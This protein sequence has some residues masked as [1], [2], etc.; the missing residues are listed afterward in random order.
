MAEAIT[1]GI[2]TIEYKLGDSQKINFPQK[3]SKFDDSQRSVEK[4]RGHLPTDIPIRDFNI[5][6][7]RQVHGFP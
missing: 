4:Q 2:Y 3:C 6:K 5:A 7:Y 1:Q